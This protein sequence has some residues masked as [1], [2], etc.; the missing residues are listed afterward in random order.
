MNLQ[1]VVIDGTDAATEDTWL[2]SSGDPLP[3][4][5]FDPNQPDGGTYEQCLVVFPGVDGNAMF[6]YIC[7][8]TDVSRALCEFQDTSGLY[9]NLHG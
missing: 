8:S 2:T 1:L 3:H 7:A 9:T 6:D 5:N 4:L